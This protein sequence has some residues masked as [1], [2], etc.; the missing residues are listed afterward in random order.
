MAVPER[1]GVWRT[2]WWDLA[3]AAEM[4]RAPFPGIKG[5]AIVLTLPGTWAVLTFR[6]AAACR[7]VHLGLVGRLLAFGGVVA[8]GADLH[9]SADIGPGLAIMHPVGVTISRCRVGRRLRVAGGITIG[10]GGFCDPR[11]DGFPTIGDGCWLFDGAKILGPVSVGDGC[12]VGANSLVRTDLPA[13]VV[14][15]GTPAR[16]LRHR[17]DL[18][19]LDLGPQAAG[20][21]AGAVG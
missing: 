13:G 17:D 5:L 3:A 20:L 18:V 6:L 15:A 19:P 7:R 4:V 10:G 1:A 8:F 14:A 9:P 21:D 12:I 16:V 2:C 11:R